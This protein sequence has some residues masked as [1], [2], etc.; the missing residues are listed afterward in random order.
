MKK[1]K[2]ILFESSNDSFREHLQNVK[3]AL[4]DSNDAYSEY[5]RNHPETKRAHDKFV[6]A[7]NKLYAKHGKHLPKDVYDFHN[8]FDTHTN[9]DSYIKSKTS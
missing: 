7:V 4:H 9:I 8:E 3:Y 5:G 6:G 2:D 1:F